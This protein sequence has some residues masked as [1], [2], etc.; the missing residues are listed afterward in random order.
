MLPVL[1]ILISTR[2]CYVVPY[3]YVVLIARRSKTH[4]TACIRRHQYSPAT[5][6]DLRP[7]RHIHQILNY[8]ITQTLMYYKLPLQISYTISIFLSMSILIF[9][10]MSL[11]IAFSQLQLIVAHALVT[12]F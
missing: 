4:N 5:T 2:S 6:H 11:Y 3:L 12:C 7:E 9:V 8:W 1:L 10:H